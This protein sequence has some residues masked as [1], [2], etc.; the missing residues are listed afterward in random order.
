[1]NVRER[2]NVMTERRGE[3]FTPATLSA[4]VGASSKD[5]VRTTL[6]V[7]SGR[8]QIVKVGNGQYRARD[9]GKSGP[10]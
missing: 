7:L 6:L 9:E 4:L 5:S 2:V 8:N 1:M 3:S 10:A